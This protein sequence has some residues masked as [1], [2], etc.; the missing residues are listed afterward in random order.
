MLL[1]NEGSFICTHINVPSC[2]PY[3]VFMPEP[4]TFLPIPELLIDRNKQSF[5]YFEEST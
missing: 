2:P 5:K 4:S 1:A 3:L